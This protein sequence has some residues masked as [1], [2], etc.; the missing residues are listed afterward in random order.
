MSP[1]FFKSYSITADAQNPPGEFPADIQDVGF[2]RVISALGGK[3]FE[4]G[5]YR[6][7]QIAQLDAARLVMER[8]FPEYAGQIRPFAYDWLGR[9]FAIDL[10][11]SPEDPEIL[12]LEVGAGEA[13]IVPGTIES[14]HD[15]VLLENRSAAL[16]SEFWEGWQELHPEPLAFSDC[17]GYKI[18]LFL[19][20]EDDYPN[21]EVIDLDVY[22]EICAQMREKI[23]GLPAGT[24]IN[25][26][27]FE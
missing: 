24:K 26:V 2:K 5:L 11:S 13:M 3:T 21:L 12:M 14:F 27:S 19:G 18:P 10:K 25:S 15:D 1:E 7:L 6:V 23:R 22:L 16:A 4:N 8:I 9:H 20:G 17:V